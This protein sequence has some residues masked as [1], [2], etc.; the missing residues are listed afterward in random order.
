MY[1]KVVLLLRTKYDNL[2]FN[3]KMLFNCQFTFVMSIFRIVT[4]IG[5]NIR[6]AEFN[7]FFENLAF[8]NLSGFKAQS[9][10]EGAT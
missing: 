2:N 6:E 4:L 3:L 7:K 8:N 10:I 5:F 1:S 9:I